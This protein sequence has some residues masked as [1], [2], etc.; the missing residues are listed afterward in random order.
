LTLRAGGDKIP[1]T[2]LK[3]KRFLKKIIIIH[4]YM[5]HKL[6]IAISGLH[7]R[8]CELLNE[9]SLANLPGV[10]AVSV[11]HKTGRAEIEYEATAPEKKR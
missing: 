4:S 2:R 10:T 1:N 8:A 3:L 11:S 7:C 9:Q 5:S 6:I